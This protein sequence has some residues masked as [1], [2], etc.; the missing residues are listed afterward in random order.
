MQIYFFSHF[1][2]QCSLTCTQKKET[3]VKDRS[4]SYKDRSGKMLKKKN[5][6]SYITPLT[7]QYFGLRPKRKKSGIPKK[8][9][10]IEN[11]PLKFS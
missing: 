3:I 2:V 9:R 7:K 1:I 6:F 11:R 4:G 5:H 8:K 10:F